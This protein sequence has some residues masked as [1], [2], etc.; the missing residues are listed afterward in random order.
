M[1]AWLECTTGGSVVVLFKLSPVRL[2]GC[3]PPITIISGLEGS[4][5]SG[6]EVFSTPERLVWD[7]LSITNCSKEV[8]PIRGVSSGELLRQLSSFAFAFSAAHV[9]F[10]WLSFHRFVRSHFCLY[11]CY[12]HSCLSHNDY[13]FI[14]IHTFTFI[15]TYDHSFVSNLYTFKTLINYLQTF[16]CMI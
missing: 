7:D 11:V 1:P 15:H 6:N 13:F 16:I 5:M 14:F 4:D 12:L 2:K 10:F 3:G 9:S 8:P